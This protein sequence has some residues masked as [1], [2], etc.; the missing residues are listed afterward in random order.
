MAGLTLDS[1]QLSRRREHLVVSVEEFDMN[2]SYR[3]GV[4]ILCLSSFCLQGFSQ[5]QPA[6]VPETRETGQIQPDLQPQNSSQPSHILLDVVVTDRSGKPIPGLAE[7]DFVVRSN[8]NLQKI[9]SFRAVG[10]PTTTEQ[11]QPPKTPVKIILMVDEVNTSFD[12]VAYER[13]QIKKFLSQNGGKLSQPLSLGFFSD[14]GTEIQNHPTQDGN[15]LLAAFDQH[16]SSLRTIRRSTGFYGAEERLDLS[17]KT[18]S[19]LAATEAQEPG[20]KMVIW[21]SPGWPLLS[22]PGVDLSNKQQ[23]QLFSTIVSVSTEL[24]QARITMYSIDPLGLAD[25]GSV[26]LFY[27]KE[28]LKP[29]TAVRNV[30]VGSLGLQVLATQTGGLALNSSNDI[31]AQIAECIADAN[32][33]YTLTIDAA[34]ADKPNDFHSIDVKVETPGLTVRTRNGYYTQPPN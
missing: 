8:G 31:S 18:L 13:E 17:L 19:R 29:V 2:L 21:I 4:F 32:A 24:R 3:A 14:N 16:E 22:G 10:G 28:F 20:R 5:Q 6:S 33:F 34:P 1:V 11:L 9:L 15:A 7:K 26:R 23:Q 27:Y 12:R 30:Q 25:A